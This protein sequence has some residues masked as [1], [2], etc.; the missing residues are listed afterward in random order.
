M[1]LISAL[2]K[3]VT[4]E[5]TLFELQTMAKEIINKFFPGL[6][7]PAFKIQNRT[8]PTQYG[9]T[10]FRFKKVNNKLVS[11]ITVTMQKI[12]LDDEKTAH[13]ILA[14]ELIHVWEF[15]QPEFI[16]NVLETG[17]PDFEKHGKDFHDWA[18]KMNAVYGPDYVTVTSDSTYAISQSRE[19]FIIIE[20][21]NDRY[22][23]A[24]TIRPSTKQKEKIAKKILERSAHVFKTKD[25]RFL[26]AADVGEGI[27][28]YKTDEIQEDLANLYDSR[29]NVD[30]LFKLNPAQLKTIEQQHQ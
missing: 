15:S 24:K 10:E 5:V 30:H 7:L 12:A 25:R 20:P 6:K 19:Y 9:T 27:S 26:G 28:V 4:S 17:R 18:K 14:H 21:F 8:N 16:Q 1:K 13:R 3:V 22:G 2:K 29:D 11:K 23:V